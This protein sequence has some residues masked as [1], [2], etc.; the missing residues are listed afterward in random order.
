VSFG[1]TKVG[2]AR[3]IANPTRGTTKRFS[4]VSS[5]GKFEYNWTVYGIHMA[6]SALR[7]SDIKTAAEHYA[8]SRVRREPFWR[9]RDFVPISCN[10]LMPLSLSQC[11]RSSQEGL[12]PRPPA[13]SPSRHG[14]QRTPGIASLFGVGPNGALELR[15]RREDQCRRWASSEPRCRLDG[16]DESVPGFHQTDSCLHNTG[17][18]AP[19]N[20]SSSNVGSVATRC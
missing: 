3:L 17:F 4:I 14:R 18:G 1:W 13:G 20:C 5:G 19:G 2:K 15:A 11:L 8:D 6:S 7:H 9:F 10:S 16:L 12:R